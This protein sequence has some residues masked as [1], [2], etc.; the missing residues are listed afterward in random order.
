MGIKRPLIKLINLFIYL[1]TSEEYVVSGGQD[2]G[3]VVYDAALRSPKPIVTFDQ[4]KSTV[5]H[6]SWVDYGNFVVELS[7]LLAYLCR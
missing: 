2:G 4:G 3:V 7:G 1:L 6:L 5:S